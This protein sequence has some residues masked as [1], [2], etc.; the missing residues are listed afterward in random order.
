MGQA[1][2]PLEEPLQDTEILVHTAR[3]LMYGKVWD[4]QAPTEFTAR[5]EA[6]RR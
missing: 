5:Q 2:P 4:G 3:K 1:R 6:Q